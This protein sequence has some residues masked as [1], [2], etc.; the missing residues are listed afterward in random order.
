MYKALYMN[1]C[2]F[3]DPVLY[4]KCIEMISDDRKDKISKL[5]NASSA[6]LSLGAGILLRIAMEYNG[7]L[8]RLNEIKY[9]MHGKPYLEDSDFH[10]SISHSGDYVICIFDDAPVGIDLQKIKNTLPRF[11]GRILTEEEEYFLENLDE[12]SKNNQ[13][14][15]FW[16]MK[17]SV[18]K[19]EGRGLRLPL[20]DISCVSDDMIIKD[21]TF[22]DHKIFLKQLDDFMPDY[23]CCICSNKRIDTLKLTEIDRNFLIKY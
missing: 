3:E 9:Q 19:W 16:A 23:T 1:V 12:R 17:E 8:S 21:M 7:C 4:N 20:K 14:Y 22:S 6:R 13:F 10:F 15:R 2:M 18:I 5:K 11:T